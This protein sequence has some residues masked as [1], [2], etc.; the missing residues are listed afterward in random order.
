MEAR[1]A[2]TFVS[3]SV[4]VWGSDLAA[5]ASAVGEAKVVGHYDEEVG[6]FG[7]GGHDWVL[8]ICILSNETALKG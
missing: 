4:N 5:K 2:E 7:F 6:T 1:V 3:Q 8:G